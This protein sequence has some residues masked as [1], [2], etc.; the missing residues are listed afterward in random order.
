MPSPGTLRRNRD[1]RLFL[2]VVGLSRLGTQV[3]FLALPLLTL[4][5][6]G[7]SARTGSLALLEGVVFL[8]M[9]L[10]GGALADHFSRRATMVG[11]ALGCAA[12]MGGLATAVTL[13]H[14]SFALI[15]AA[16]V[17]IGVLGGVFAPA[18]GASIRTI[19]AEGDLLD[20]YSTLEARS[21]V[22]FLIGPPLGGFLFGISAQVPLWTDAA[23][24]VVCALGVLAVRTP[25]NRPRAPAPAVGA[26]VS[27]DRTQDGRTGTVRSLAKGAAAGMV[28]IWRNA[29]LRYC[30]LG[31]AALNT[32]FQSAIFL[33]ILAFARDGRGATATGLVISAW[34]IGALAG[35]LLARRLTKRY[36]ARQTL[37]GVTWA[38]AA[39][40][41]LLAVAHGAVVA[42][43][44]VVAGCGL[45][46]PSHN[47]VAAG[48]LARLTPDHLQ[49][50]AQ[51]AAGLM[52]MAGAP[53]GPLLAGI[54]FQ[55]FALWTLFVALGVLIAAVALAGQAS[56]ALRTVPAAPGQEPRLQTVAGP[57]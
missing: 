29:F 41:P 53:F 3:S 6:T 19:V 25:L 28:F 23:S 47:A 42:V 44:A 34:G 40:V 21:A 54:A 31:T 49:G 7:S 35:S 24:Y 10:P 32:A 12:A 27:P 22:L 15:A 8:A 30:A 13:H 14:A 43:I 55:S 45:L 48:T 38:C 36:D 18:S 56:A 20:A 50:R 39:L 57:S 46:A 1:F 17:V 9:S 5:L 52:A 2:V 26:D 11:C 33:V 4:R 16:V 37:L 51:S